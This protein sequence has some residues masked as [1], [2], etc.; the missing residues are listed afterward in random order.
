MKK[1]IITGGPNAGKSTLIDLLSQSGHRVLTES[2]RLIIEREGIY[3]WDD[4]KLFCE[5]VSNEQLRRE[6][7]LTGAMVFL[8]R[9]LVDP[10]AYAEL[11]G[12]RLH[13]SIY[14][15]IDDAKYERRVFF[16][17]MLP[18]YVTDRQ[19]QESSELA[20][21]VH[22]TLRAVYL[23][24]GFDLIDVPLFFDSEEPSKNLRPQ[25]LIQEV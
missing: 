23:R 5:A 13:H 8:D 25:F 11:A 1:F 16:L 12:V 19:R 10:V 9:S 20:V 18:H 22:E 15:G 17:E 4:Q 14:D 3:P 6:G 24:L 7:D 21:E 2:A